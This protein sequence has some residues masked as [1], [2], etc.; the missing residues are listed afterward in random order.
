MPL[1]KKP[2]L[3]QLLLL[4]QSDIDLLLLSWRDRNSKRLSSSSLLVSEE[5]STTEEKNVFFF[6]FIRERAHT[7]RINFYRKRKKRFQKCIRKCP[8]LWRDTTRG[9]HRSSTSIRRLPHGTRE[10]TEQY[11][12]TIERLDVEKKKSF[13]EMQS[14][15]ILF[16]S[17]SLSPRLKKKKLAGKP[18]SSLFS[19]RSSS[20]ASW[21]LYP[22]ALS[23]RACPR[24]RLGA[25]QRTCRSPRRGGG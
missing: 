14:S 24:S 4:L 2:L 1:A 16:F 3:L 23:S 20:P 6:L 7:Q 25:G 21:E 9:T 22:P 15:L 18:S 5:K 8:R 13:E 12:E 19:S 17:L 10:Q 11:K